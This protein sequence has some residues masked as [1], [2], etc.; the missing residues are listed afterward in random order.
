MRGYLSEVDQEAI[1]G[2]IGGKL[3]ECIG[4]NWNPEDLDSFVY[5]HL[6]FDLGDLVLEPGSL[7]EDV[8]MISVEDF[9]SDVLEKGYSHKD[10]NFNKIERP[11]SRFDL[12]DDKGYCHSSVTLWFGD[13]G[14]KAAGLDDILVRFVDL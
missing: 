11:F 13:I 14:M 10:I 1:R 4:F 7:A 9:N 3:I 12:A 5:I 8:S 6:I 2:L